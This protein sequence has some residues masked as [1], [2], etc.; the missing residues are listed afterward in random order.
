MM[1]IWFIKN[2]AAVHFPNCVA[3][4]AA[5]ST[6]CTFVPLS[7]MKVNASFALEKS[8]FIIMSDALSEKYIQKNISSNFNWPRLQLVLQNRHF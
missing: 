1:R 4:K 3:T 2:N 5:L 7:F 6:R 8:L